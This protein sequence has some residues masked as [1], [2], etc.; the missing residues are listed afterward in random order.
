LAPATTNAV[1]T[2]VI[3]T[4]LTTYTYDADGNTLSTTVSDTTGGDTIRGV[5]NVYNDF[6]ELQTV[7][8]PEQNTTAYTSSMAPGW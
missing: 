6:G 1:N 2:R 3:H 4:A 5:G 7:T 8:D